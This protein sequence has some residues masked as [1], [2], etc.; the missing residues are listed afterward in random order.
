MTTAIAEPTE[1][2]DE[3]PAIVEWSKNLTI[4]NADD[5]QEAADRLKQIKSLSKKIAD[6]F[7]PL[8]RSADAAKKAILDREKEQLKPLDAAEANAKRVMMAYLHEEQRK[9]LEAKRKAQAEADE[10]A[11]REREALEKKAAA[12]KKPETVAKYAEAAA[13]VVAPV[14][15]VPADVPKVEWISTRKVWKAQV[16]D[17]AEVPREFLIVDQKALDSYAKSFQERAKVPGV[18]FYTEEIMSAT[19]R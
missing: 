11:R 14:I 5:Y 6:F 4:A 9:A 2:A 13:S 17:A 12:A 10:R 1:L 16:I 8:K 15:H 18:R 19:G 7:T 3:V